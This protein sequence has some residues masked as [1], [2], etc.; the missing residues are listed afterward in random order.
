MI[1]SMSVASPGSRAVAMRLTDPPTGGAIRRLG[2]VLL[3]VVA[4]AMVGVSSAAGASG[5]PT[6]L[7]YC[8]GDDWE[9]AFAQQ[10]SYIY[11]AITHYVGS[12][13]CDP[14]SGSPA[15]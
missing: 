8:G 2:R 5:S 14:A 10:G 12:T 13:A 15:A 7:G 3:L 1:V 4:V 6:R 9:P 11:D